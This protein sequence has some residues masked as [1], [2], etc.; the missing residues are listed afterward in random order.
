MNSAIISRRDLIFWYVMRAEKL[1]KKSKKVHFE[2]FVE[3]R[4]IA[5][6][7]RLVLNI[8]D[9]INLLFQTESGKVH[10]M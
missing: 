2:N 8:I 4:S 6:R 5:P 9:Y 1:Y 3:Y 7:R 10:G